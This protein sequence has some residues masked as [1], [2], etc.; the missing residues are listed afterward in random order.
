LIAAGLIRVPAFLRRFGDEES[1]FRSGMLP[2]DVYCGERPPTLADYQ[3]DGVAADVSY[4][5]AETKLRV[6]AD[7]ASLAFGRLV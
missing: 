4:V 2:E 5:P 7:P 3:D 1:L 6:R